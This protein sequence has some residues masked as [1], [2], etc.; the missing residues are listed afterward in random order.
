MKQ[1]RSHWTDFDET[2]F[3][4]LFRK[5]AEKIH[6]SLKSDKNNEYLTSRL[7]HIYD[8]ISLDSF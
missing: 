7:L 4:R 3:L 6:V 2:L 8:N 5:Y 1:L